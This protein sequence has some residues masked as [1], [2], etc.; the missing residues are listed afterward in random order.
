MFVDRANFTDEEKLIHEQSEGAYTFR[1]EWYDQLPHQ[2]GN[3][4]DDITYQT[5]ENVEQWSIFYKNCTT[6][7]NAII[8]VRFSALFNDM[9]EFEVELAPVP[10]KDGQGKDI[11]VNWRLYDSF[12]PKGTFYTDSNG[13]EMQERK[14]RNITTNNK[15]ASNADGYNYATIAAN[16]FPVNAA[17]AMRDQSGLSNIQVT[18]LNDRTQGG[19]ADLSQ[20]G[21]IELMQ[22]RR[23]LRDDDL[24]VAEALNETDSEN[25]G[26]RVTAKYYMQI[27]DWT[28]EMSKQREMQI[29]LD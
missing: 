14:I 23:I 12:D 20:K 16:Y 13:L 24:G 6:E 9:V 2:Y 28:R 8:K 29:R 7:E 25:E 5:G 3:L 15:L 26:V 19:S 22:H 27:F 18:I 10:V 21:T 17:I 1:P 4:S 11:T